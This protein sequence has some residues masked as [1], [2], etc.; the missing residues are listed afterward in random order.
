MAQAMSRAFYAVTML[1]SPVCN[2]LRTTL[3]LPTPRLLTSRSKLIFTNDT[4]PFSQVDM[5]ISDVIDGLMGTAKSVL[6]EQGVP[7]PIEALATA[8]LID[9]P[10]VSYK[11]ARL[12]D[13]KNDGEVTFGALDPAKFDNN[14]LVNLDNVSQVGFWEANLDDVAVDGQSLGLQGR[15]AI[16]DTGTT[17]ILAPPNVGCS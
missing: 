7:T 3:E 13:Q 15:T 14:T 5:A 10:I 17:I 2:S 12:S 8:G 4:L 6:S 1:I 16:V 11:V 9:A